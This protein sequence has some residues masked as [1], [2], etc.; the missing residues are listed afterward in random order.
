MAVLRVFNHKQMIGESNVAGLCE[1]KN[2]DEYVRA[3]LSIL[4]SNSDLARQIRLAV[5]HVFGLE[6]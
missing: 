6:E 1:L 4:K 2:R 5:K 3:V